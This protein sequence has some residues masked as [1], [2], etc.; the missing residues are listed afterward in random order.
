MSTHE[1]GV[2]LS[3][4]HGLSELLFQGHWSQWQ[5]SGL[6]IKIVRA[7][8]MAFVHKTNDRGL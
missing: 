5:A 8:N 4:S 3:G 2:I 7:M 6:A 1:V